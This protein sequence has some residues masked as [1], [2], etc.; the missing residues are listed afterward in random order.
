MGSET[1]IQVRVANDG[2]S[3]AAGVGLSI[4]LPAGMELIGARGPADF[5]ADAGVLIFKSIDSLPA[6]KAAVYEVQARGKRVG[7]QRIRA[8]VA[9]ESIPEPVIT[10]AVTQFTE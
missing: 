9:S 3:D 6:G 5:V 7:H 4:E 2:S 10:E 1:L 8:R